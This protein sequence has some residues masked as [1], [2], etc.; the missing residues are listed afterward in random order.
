MSSRRQRHWRRALPALLAAAA[1]AV[2]ILVPTTT[3]SDSGIAAGIVRAGRLAPCHELKVRGL[4][5]HGGCE[6]LVDR[7]PMRMPVASLLGHYR[8]ARC[9]LQSSMRIG[10]T[11]A[12]AMYDVSLSPPPNGVGG[13]ACGD[14][15]AC[16][17]SFKG[18][19]NAS[20]N[21]KLPWIGQMTS[22]TDNRI[23]AHIDMCL[24]SCLG[25][26]QGRTHIDFTRDTTGGWRMSARAAPI[27]TSGMTLTGRW[28]LHATFGGDL[29]LH[30]R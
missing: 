12:I 5:V 25:R 21:T 15:G 1:I 30:S 29:K 24:D 8:F 27:G 2:A 19:G 22:A 7:K 6:I 18:G 26:F 13:I 17:R 3:A 14:I 9:G 10:P 28:T 20:W 23:R 4:G 16:R 11:G